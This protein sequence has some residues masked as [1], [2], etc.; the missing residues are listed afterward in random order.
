MLAGSS[1]HQTCFVALTEVSIPNLTRY[2]IRPGEVGM[3]VDD[4]TPYWYQISSQSIGWVGSLLAVFIVAGYGDSMAHAL[5]GK[6]TNVSVDFR[7]AIVVSVTCA[8]GTVLMG[9]RMRT[10]SRRNQ[11]LARRNRSLEA[12][13]ANLRKGLKNLGNISD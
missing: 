10:M 4:R 5:A 3:A 8:I 13:N 6:N 12:D 7:I 2:N 9:I 11:R 1:Y